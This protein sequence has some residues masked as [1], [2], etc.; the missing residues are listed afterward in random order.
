MADRPLNPGTLDKGT[1]L[2]RAR[3]L[4]AAHEGT[5]DWTIQRVTACSNIVLMAWF[6]A[7]LIQIHKLDYANLHDWLDALFPASAMIMLIVSLFW[8]ARNGL[9]I[10]FDDYVHEKGNWFAVTTV[11][12]LL[13]VGGA[14]FAI[15]CV[16]KIALGVP[17]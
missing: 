5:A 6:V 8:H 14:V 9:Q 3:G 16:L 1:P 15:V 2:G 10:M 12:N 4:G 13:A 11:F 17:A 7:S